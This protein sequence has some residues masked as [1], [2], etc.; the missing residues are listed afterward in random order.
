MG[1]GG[2]AAGEGYGSANGNAN[3]DTNGNANSPDGSS[4]LPPGTQ[5]DPFGH[6]SADPFG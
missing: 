1:A 4:T 5:A 2:V 6:I 3:G